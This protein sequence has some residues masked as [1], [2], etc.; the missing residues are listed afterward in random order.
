MKIPRPWQG[1][2]MRRVM[3][4]ANPDT[5]PRLVIVPAAWGD[6][7]AGALAELVPG[8]GQAALAAA[9]ET[10]IKPIAE[11][12]LRAGLELPLAERLHRMLL[13]R[14]GAPTASV[15]QAGQRG[16]PGF[17][18]NLASFHDAGHGFDAASFAEAAETAVMALT[19]AAPAA[20]RIEVT[21]A[22]LAGLLAALGIE[23]GSDASI[24]IA[25][26]IAAVLRGRAEAASGTLAQLF[27]SVAPALLG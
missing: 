21:V 16:M 5:P 18:L 6:E 24:A 10:W 19:L 3:A 9:A 14:H 8:G 7:A 20:S 22:D 13:L 2:R 12:A 4:A 1:V 17:V 27:G 25:R 26:C 15:W 11:R 23:Y